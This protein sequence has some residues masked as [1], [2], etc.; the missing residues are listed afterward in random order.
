M[1]HDLYFLLV[2]SILKFQ[3]HNHNKYYKIVIQN[4]FGKIHNIVSMKFIHC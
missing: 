2:I 1:N 3:K 4:M